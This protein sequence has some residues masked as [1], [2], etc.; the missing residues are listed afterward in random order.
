M[1]V[2]FN[3]IS[4]EVGLVGLSIVVNVGVPVVIVDSVVG[5]VVVAVEVAE[6]LE[7]D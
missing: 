6:H 4:S 3:G 2:S 5:V 1:V 7:L